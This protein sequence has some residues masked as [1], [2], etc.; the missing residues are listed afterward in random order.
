MLILF[1]VGAAL[2]AAISFAV[3]TLL[4]VPVLALLGFG[5]LLFDH[6]IWLTLAAVLSAAFLR[7]LA[8]RHDGFGN[9]KSDVE[10]FY[11]RWLRAGAA[12][13][14]T[15]AWLA[16]SALA[17]SVV[18]PH[19]AVPPEPAAPYVSIVVAGLGVGTAIVLYVLPGVLAQCRRQND[20]VPDRQ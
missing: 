6:R 15:A 19:V 13:G 5:L 14:I 11:E 3:M 17:S 9:D 12:V 18:L 7:F 8:L 1:V 16:G 20:A 4:E 2:T 10:R